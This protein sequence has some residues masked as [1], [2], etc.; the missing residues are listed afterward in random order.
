VLSDVERKG[1]FMACANSR[2][3]SSLELA[4]IMLAL[5]SFIFAMYSVFGIS[6]KVLT[7]A[8]LSQEKRP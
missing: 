3:Q 8:H 1:K 7:G 4:L 2:G 5:T 6:G